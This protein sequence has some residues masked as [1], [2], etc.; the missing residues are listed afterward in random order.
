MGKICGLH[1][2]IIGK[3]IAVAP[4]LDVVSERPNLGSFILFAM[5]ETGFRL[6]I[7]CISGKDV[8]KSNSSTFHANVGHNRCIH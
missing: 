3:F 5:C 4:H 8:N 1:L 7:V 2:P 6:S